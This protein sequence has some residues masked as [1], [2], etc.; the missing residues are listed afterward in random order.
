M[1]LIKKKVT[2]VKWPVI[3][4][5]PIDGGQWKEETYTGVFRK[6]GITELAELANKGDP[7]LIKGVIEGWED[8]KDE[9]GNDI[10]FTPETLNEMMEDVHFLR[11]TVQA[12]LGMQQE[13]PEKN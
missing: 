9:E 7:L 11:A 12:V 13:A 3:C 1:A 2:S 5:S 6:I 10:P 4:K 8:I